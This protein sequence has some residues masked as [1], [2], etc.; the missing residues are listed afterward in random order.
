MQRMPLCVCLS[1]LLYHLLR[2]FD[3]TVKPRAESLN[4]GSNAHQKKHN[5]TVLNQQKHS[6]K[7]IFT[8]LL[9]RQFSAPLLTTKHDKREK[10]LKT[11]NLC[12]NEQYRNRSEI[13]T[14]FGPPKF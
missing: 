5:K 13:W 12:Q 9:Y 3:L 8:S 10:E 14:F 7:S 2:H 11:L 1:K 4:V 6:T